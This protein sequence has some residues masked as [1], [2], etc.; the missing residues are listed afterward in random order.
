MTLFNIF[1]ERKEQLD[2]QKN[3]RW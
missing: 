1:N 3:Y 2:K